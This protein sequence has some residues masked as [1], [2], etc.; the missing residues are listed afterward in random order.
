MK[1]LDDPVAVRAEYASERGLEGR[2][3]AQQFAKGPDARRVVL[4]AAAEASPH[5]V[6]DVGCGTGDLSER[7]FRE[8]RVELVAVDQSE[9]MVELTRARGID[10]RVGDVE[11]LLFADGEFDCAIVAWM[12]Y[13]VPDVSRALAEL[14]RVLRPGGRLVAATN[15][16]QHLRE[17]RQLVGAPSPTSPF[18]AE[19]G[20]E[21]LRGRFA[22]V[23]RR[24]AFGWIDFP[25]QAEM[26]EYV[27]AARRLW[28]DAR[29]QVDI[30]RPLRVRTGPVVFVAEK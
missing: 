28:P 5:R 19:N 23:E 16:T 4:D 3:A 12:L 26:Q 13:H 9:R 18:S 10:A 20:E 29:P 14:A 24:D 1:R 17:L 6:L 25:G 2:I 22:T 15:S 30:D 7:I 21:Q 27:D 8:L 11:E